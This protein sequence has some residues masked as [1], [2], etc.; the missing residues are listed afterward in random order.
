MENL[1]ERLMQRLIALRLFECV[2]TL[3]LLGLAATVVA[4]P[5]TIER[6][7]FRYMLVKFTPLA[8][9]LLFAALGML[10]LVALYANG[11]WPMWGPRLRAIGACGAAMLWAWMALALIVMTRDTGALP[12]A[13]AACIGLAL[14]EIVSCAVAGSDVRRAADQ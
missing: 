11:R 8:L 2:T 10:R 1:A 3:I 7:E 14:G 6:G 13:A 9:A 5:A 12:L 4:S